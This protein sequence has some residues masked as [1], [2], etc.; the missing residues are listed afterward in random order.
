MRTLSIA[1]LFTSTVARAADPSCAAPLTAGVASIDR[2]PFATI[3]R[4][5]IPTYDPTTRRAVVETKKD[6]PIVRDCRGH[7]ASADWSGAEK[8]DD[9]GTVRDGGRLKLPDGRQAVWLLTSGA[10]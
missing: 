6:Q 5:V 3:A 4:A 10:M 9:P 1:L 2:V 7:E 8:Q